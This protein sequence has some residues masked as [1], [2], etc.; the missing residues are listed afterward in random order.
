[1]VG[2][3][4]TLNAGSSSLKFAIFDGTTSLTAKQIPVG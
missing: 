2:S 1:M 4:L 3:I